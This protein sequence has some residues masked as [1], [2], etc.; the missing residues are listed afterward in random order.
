MPSY[1]NVKGIYE[2]QE[3]LVSQPETEVFKLGILRLYI[4]I[5]GIYH[6]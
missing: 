6:G 4:Q 2:R 1:M 3:V 5:N